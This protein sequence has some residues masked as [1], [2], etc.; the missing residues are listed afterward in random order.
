MTYTLN[1]YQNEAAEASTD[2]DL[3]EALSNLLT[4]HAQITRMVIS[5]DTAGKTIENAKASL[6]AALYNVAII[7]NQFN[8]NLEDIAAIQLQR[9]TTQSASGRLRRVAMTGTERETVGL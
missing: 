7:A 1:Y 3:Y 4:A 2:I 6:G 5:Q 9:L 8:L